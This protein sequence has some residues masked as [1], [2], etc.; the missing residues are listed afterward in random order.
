[1][2]LIK[3]SSLSLLSIFFCFP[4]NAQVAGFGENV[5]SAF[6]KAMLSAGFKLPRKGILLG[7]QVSCC[8]FE[9]GAKT[10]HCKRERSIYFW[11]LLF[12]CP[13]ASSIFLIDAKTIFKICFAMKY[14]WRSFLY[15][16]CNVFEQRTIFIKFWEVYN[17]NAMFQ[18]MDGTGTDLGQSS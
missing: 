17:S 15:L 6:L 2:P 1:M 5:H 11:Y 12:L 8:S 14:S 9:C 4:P 3:V 13:V 18:S 10:C 7:V 16:L